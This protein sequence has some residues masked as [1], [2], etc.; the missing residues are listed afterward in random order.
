[1]VPHQLYFIDGHPV[2]G[3]FP[4]RNGLL[5]GT[6][7]F[8]TTLSAQSQSSVITSN[9][10][11]DFV[12]DTQQ[13]MAL[14]KIK[15]HSNHN[16]KATA[17]LFSD[18]LKNKPLAVY[19]LGDV[20]AVGS[21]NRRWRKADKFLDSCRKNNITVHGLLGNHDLMWGRREGEKKFQERFPDNVDIGYVS[22]ADSIAVIMLNS[23]FRKLSNTEINKQ[24][25][26][27]EAAIES[28][29]NDHSIIAI[30]V[31]CHHAP[32]S[33]SLT[34]GSSRQV[35][36]YFLP[37][38]IQTA[39]C[40]LFITGHAHAFEHFKLSGKDFL[41]IGG[42][43]GLHQPLDA[44]ANAIPDLASRYKP[45]FHY[46]S[47]QRR[48]NSLL[49]TSRFLKSDFSGIEKGYSFEIGR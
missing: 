35:Q 20:V 47:I 5:F 48:G 36:R 34:V 41:V 38:F 46:L 40:R 45:I 37:A 9:R 18:I 39:K 33:N 10:E 14:E 42:G 6:L 30:I 15:L 49:L 43:G 19:M 3:V 2:R 32:Y 4:Y 26:W 7:L 12:S 1:M 44:S 24:V 16:L 23:N 31:S 27:Y 29:K 8:L 28:L 21:S 17:L 25:E 13:P 11:I 22:M